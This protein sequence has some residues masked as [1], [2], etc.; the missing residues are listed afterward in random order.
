VN[1]KP[2]RDGLPAAA[3]S[4]PAGAEPV[5]PAP[6]CADDVAP[7]VE[8]HLLDIVGVRPQE[9]S[10]TEL[11]QA[12][13]WVAR[14]RLSRRWVAGDSADRGARARRVAYLSMEFLIG[15]SLGNA[16]AALGMEGAAAQAASAHARTL[17][18]LQ[19]HEPDAALGNGGLGR[20]AACFLDSMAT[21]GLPSI[22][23]GIRYEFGM[24]AQTIQGG[25]QVEHPDPWLENGTPWEFPRPDIAW[26]VRFGGWVEPLGDGRAVWHHAGMVQAKAY[27]M[28]VPGHGT[29]RVATLRLWRAAAPAHIDLHAFNS[30]DYARAAEFKNE[31]ENISWVLYPNDSTPA[32]RELRLRQEYFFTSA[33]LQDVLARH[34]REHGRLD[35]LHEAV[36]IH[37]ND[38][39]PAIG[40]AELMRLL[41]DEHRMP[42]EQAWAITERSFSYTNHTLMPEALETWPVALIEQVL[43][44]HMEIV[45]RINEQFLL[46]AARRRPGDVDFLGRV[47]L[48]EENGERRVRM[49]HLSVVGS[50]KVNGVSALHSK[51]LVDTV[52][53]DLA[54]VWPERFVNVTNGVTPRRWLAQANPG[55]ASLIDDAIGTGWRRDL[56]ELERLRPLADDTAFRERFLAVKLASKRRLAPMLQ[57]SAGVAIDPASLFDVQVKRIHE[58]KRQLLNLLHVVGRYLAIADDPQ[59][60]WLP[61]TVVFAGKAASGYAAAKSVIRLIHDVAAVVNRDLRVAGRLV[62][63]FVP[64]YGVS[65]AEALMPAADLSEQISTAGTEASGTGNMKLALNGA[66]T[67]GTDDGANIEIRHAVGDDNVFVFGRRADEVAAI[68]AAGYRPAEI[69]DAAPPLKR[70]LDAIGGGMFSP[71]EPGRYRG[72]V[73]TLLTSDPYLLLADHADYVA[74]QARVDALFRDPAAWAGKAILNVAGMGPFSADRTIGIYAS[75]IWRVAPAR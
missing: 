29:E 9:A 20:L 10:A 53:R 74:T 52:F 43:P 65:V 57:A 51:L 49:A 16:L 73:D 68:R 7:H 25:R 37:L 32:G 21:L 63:V 67:I 35:T 50:H 58:Y 11:L 23:Y 75:E 3:P 42:W 39:H 18:D 46:Q 13:S 54:E 19:A 14:E 55:L 72:L 47:S 17:E 31:Y 56:D 64:N 45:Y 8:R 66:I 22:G 30:G 34:L 41:V 12:L 5:D 38:T 62:V 71:D 60:P 59:R 48:I 26:P 2:D 1:D 15:R 6:G 70:V 69:A 61:R 40:V 28:V 27:D 44:R 36:A 33:S 24:F 4:A